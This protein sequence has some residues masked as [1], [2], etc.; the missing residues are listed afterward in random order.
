MLIAEGTSGR[1]FEV[2]RKGEVVGNGLALHDRRRDQPISWRV[3]AY[4]YC[5]DD[6]AVAGR[7]LDPAR[8]GS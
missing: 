2:T 6:P 5:L 4:R 3:R 1:L 7:E 8:T